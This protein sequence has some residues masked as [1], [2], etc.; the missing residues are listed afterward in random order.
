MSLYKSHTST[1]T[2]SYTILFTLIACA[3]D[4]HDANMLVRP[5]PKSP[6]QP[7]IGS[8]T[9][10]ILTLSRHNLTFIYDVYMMGMMYI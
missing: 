4:P 6:T 2:H 7:Q 3:I 10:I 1:Y 5:N 9:L 8:T